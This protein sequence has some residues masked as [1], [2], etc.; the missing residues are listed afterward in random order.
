MS[1]SLTLKKLRQWLKHGSSAQLRP[2]ETASLDAWR[3]TL[4]EQGRV[5][6][7]EQLTRLTF[8]QRQGDGKLVCFYDMADRAATQWPKELLFPCQLSEVAVARVFLK[9]KSERTSREI[10][11]DVALCRGR[12]FGLEFSRSP[13][14][15][16]DGFKMLK[17]DVLVD[18][19]NNCIDESATGQA[20]ECLLAAIDAKLPGEYFALVSGEKATSING[21][22][23]Y[24]VPQVR[25]VV[26]PDQNYYLLAEKDGCGAIGVIAEDQSGQLYYLDYENDAPVK[27]TISLLAFIEDYGLDT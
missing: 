19:M 15:L 17:T 4:P 10:K 18:P 12:F 3:Q 24:D 9:A 27:I 22:N 26:Q 16:E 5:L 14:L 8:R 23:I 1:F 25:K 2:Y 13:L 6:L 7:D 20:R 11:A 21:W